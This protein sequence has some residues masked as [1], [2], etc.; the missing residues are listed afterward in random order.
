MLSSFLV[1]PLETPYPIPPPPAF[2]RVFLHPPVVSTL[3]QQEL[4]DNQSF[5]QQ[6]I[7]Q[8]SVFLFLFVYIFQ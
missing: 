3:D 2:M 1:S 5:Q 4:H 6:F 7:Q 8:T